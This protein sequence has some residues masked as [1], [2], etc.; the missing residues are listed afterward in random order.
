VIRL[1]KDQLR[2]PNGSDALSRGSPR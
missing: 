1:N 2:Q